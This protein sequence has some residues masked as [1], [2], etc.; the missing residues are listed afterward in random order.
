MPDPTSPRQA[1]KVWAGVEAGHKA[2]HAR[3]PY[4]R[5]NAIATG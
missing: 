5:A 1:R 4:E 3:N 2:M